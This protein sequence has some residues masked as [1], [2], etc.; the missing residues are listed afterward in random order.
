MLHTLIVP[1]LSWAESGS[2]EL[3]PAL[4][5]ANIKKRNKKSPVIPSDKF[6]R[7]S[8]SFVRMK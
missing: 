7:G 2:K 1:E 5:V 6:Q 8:N 3:H 4:T